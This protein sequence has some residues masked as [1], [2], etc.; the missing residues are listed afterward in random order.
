MS[1]NNKKEMPLEVSW[2]SGGSS[3]ARKRSGSGGGSGKGEYTIY[4][5]ETQFTPDAAQELLLSRIKDAAAALYGS[6]GGELSALADELERMAEGNMLSMRGGQNKGSMYSIGMMR[7]MTP[8][9]GSSY[10]TG[11]GGMYDFGAIQNRPFYGQGNNGYTSEGIPGGMSDVYG[12]QRMQRYM[13]GMYNGEQYQGMAPG[14]QGL[15]QYNMGY[16]PSMAGYTQYNKFNTPSM[17]GYAPN[18]YGTAP[19]MPG[20]APSGYGTAPSMPGYAPNGYG[21]APSVPGYAPNGYGIAPSMAGYAPNGSG[22]RQND[23]GS[24]ALVNKWRREARQLKQSVPDFD[25][26]QALSD[27]N[28]TDAL[29]RG[30][31][32]AEAY[33]ESVRMPKNQPRGAVY[34]NGQSARRGTGEASRNPADLSP[35]DF[36]KYI[37]KLKEQ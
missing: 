6:T 29:A 13:P 4:A 23:G 2:Q 17:P 32:V 22:Y 9:S 37:E 25:L 5:G 18:G 1:E 21:T 10:M 8:E 35:E 14:A 27:K 16:T 31:S 28:F 33:A 11:A 24:D 30:M 12:A 36:K 15:I 20:Y 7:G 26:K 34:Q 3:S 19:S